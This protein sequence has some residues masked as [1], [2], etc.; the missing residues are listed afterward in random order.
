MFFVCRERAKIARKL[1]DDYAYKFPQ[2]AQKSTV[3]SNQGEEER[4]MLKN[5][6]QNPRLLEDAG[7][8]GAATGQEGEAD[9]KDTTGSSRKRSAPSGTCSLDFFTYIMYYRKE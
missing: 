9:N 4:K 6:S 3:R 1:R 7:S 8:S 2:T 5:G